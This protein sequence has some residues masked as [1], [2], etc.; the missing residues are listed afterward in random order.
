MSLSRCRHKFRPRYTSG[1][2]DSEVLSQMA[3]N[4]LSA[5]C[6]ESVWSQFNRTVAE[7]RKAKVYAGDVCIKCGLRVDKGEQ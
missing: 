3:V 6:P 4:L 7:Y 1:L 5:D 2:A